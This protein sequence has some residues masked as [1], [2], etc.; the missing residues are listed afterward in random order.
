MKVY[1]ILRKKLT[2]FPAEETS[3]SFVK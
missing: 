3:P 2:H 1:S